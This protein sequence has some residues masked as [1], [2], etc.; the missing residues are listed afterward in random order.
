MNRKRVFNIASGIIGIS[1]LFAAVKI[2]H[3]EL[4]ACSYHDI[5]RDLKSI[6]PRSAA[7]AVLLTVLNFLVLGAYE[8]LGFKYIRNS[9][10]WHKTLMTSFIAFS[11]SNN[12]G[13]YSITGSAVRYRLY[14]QWGLSTLDIAKLVAFS[15]G[16]TF[17]LGLSSVSSAVFLADPLV[18]PGVLHLPFTSTKSLGYLFALPVLSFILYSAFAK[19]TV[20]IGS[21]EFD[22]PSLSLSFSLLF[23]SCMDWFLFASVLYALL[24][25]LS[26]SFVHFLSIFLTAQVIGL[27]SHVPGGLGVFESMFILFIPET[28]TSQ[29]IGTLLIF[30][31]IY[32][33]FPLAISA[34]LL[35]GRELLRKR[36][37]LIG[38]AQGM[39]EII[40]GVLPALFSGMTFIGGIILLASGTTPGE[41]MRMHWLTY[42][43][44]LPVLEI[45][46][47]V[48]SL[49]GVTLLIL[50]RGIHLRL[51]SAWYM[52]SCLLA[53][54]AAFT[55]IKGLDYEE[56]LILLFMLL[57]LLP[58]RRYF[59]R[60]ASFVNERF[61]LGWLLAV[62]SVLVSSAGLGF[63]VYK[64]VAYSH[65]LWWLFDFDNHASRFLRASVGT[66]VVLLVFGLL[67][68]M[69]PARKK[70]VSDAMTPEL[71]RPIIEKSAAS[72]SC[73]AYIGDK[74]FLLG[75][76]GDAFIMYGVQGNSWIVM[77]DPVGNPASFQALLWNFKELSDL[78]AGRTVFYEVGKQNLPLYLDLGLTLLKIGEEGRVDL[79]TFSLE[80]GS[81][82][83]LRHSYNRIGQEGWEF[84]IISGEEAEKSIPSLKHI[85]NNW[86]ERKRTKEKRFS[87]GYFSADYLVRTPIGVLTKE[88]RISAFSNLWISADREELSIDLMRYD[89]NAPKGTMDSLLIHIMLWGKEQGYKWFN[90]GMAPFSGLDN[91]SIA[92][93]WNRLGGYL[94]IHGEEFYNFQGL[95]NYKE[96][97]NPVWEPKYIAVPGVFSLP[98]ILKDISS[99]I[100]G[101]LLGVVEK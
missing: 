62:L 99:L 74:S 76:S 91:R 48:A 3:S 9:L 100:S 47:F 88:D 67:K 11:F 90:L 12:V 14:S 21:W 10:P 72:N 43:L 34:V 52:T 82:K 51:D 42:I 94:F 41:Q 89:E 25:G 60:K 4:Q 5:L 6:P 86:L 16:L 30:R 31:F 26:I 44:P 28:N 68:L 71:V 17:W 70:T 80:G 92:P 7:W 85:S 40:G 84:K 13:F 45:S 36:R 32:Y 33:L 2:L 95:R 83:G 98:I 50:S 64:H 54:G 59:Y 58:N 55:F 78:H 63:F 97:F 61:S 46:H 57:I 18:L 8:I 77:G 37:Q 66:Y 96:K 39:G 20:H 75:E 19:K 38:A 53:G 1:L 69:S 79:K 29:M 101:G 22:P 56:A 73:L 81:K 35:G 87:L 93:L 27:I 65:E 15:S 49:F 24:P 23:L